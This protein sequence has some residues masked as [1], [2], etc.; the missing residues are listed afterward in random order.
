MK[1]LNIIKSVANKKLVLRLKSVIGY[2]NWK[3]AP[4]GLNAAETFHSENCS[5]NIH[6]TNTY[7]YVYI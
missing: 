4:Q 1:V 5:C 3:Q 2:G 6:L 7:I